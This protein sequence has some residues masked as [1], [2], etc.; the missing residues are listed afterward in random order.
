MIAFLLCKAGVPNR[1]H[2]RRKGHLQKIAVWPASKIW[3]F[4]VVFHWFCIWHCLPRNQGGT[5]KPR[6]AA[7]HGNCTPPRISPSCPHCLCLWLDRSINADAVIAKQPARAVFGTDGIAH[8]C[9]HTDG[10]GASSLVAYRF[11]PGTSANVFQIPNIQLAR[12]MRDGEKPL[13]LKPIFQG[14]L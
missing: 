3:L 1:K 11:P 14:V 7:R 2:R 8:A 13:T 12:F 4:S 9:K 6:M 10:L 5:L